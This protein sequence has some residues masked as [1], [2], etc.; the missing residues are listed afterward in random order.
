MHSNFNVPTAK[1]SVIGTCTANLKNKTNHILVNYQNSLPK[2]ITSSNSYVIVFGLTVKT[3]VSPTACRYDVCT[4]FEAKTVKQV[5]ATN[6]ILEHYQK[7]IP[8]Y[9][10]YTCKA[11]IVFGPTVA[12]F[13]RDPQN[14]KCNSHDVCIRHKK[15]HL[16]VLTLVEHLRLLSYGGAAQHR[17]S[18][19]LGVA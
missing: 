5:Y 4:S 7:L 2:Y 18:W 17:G 15:A 8:Q 14:H 3:F 19:R 6:F 9:N 10:D 16:Q 12:M 11:V 1:N 13:I